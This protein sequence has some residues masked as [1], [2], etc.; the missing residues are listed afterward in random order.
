MRKIVFKFNRLMLVLFFL[1]AVLAI[2][3]NAQT[4]ETVKTKT[5]VVIGTA[6]VK[7]TDVSTAREKSY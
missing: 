6:P 2:P 1:A 3:H 5:F 4:Q 7:G